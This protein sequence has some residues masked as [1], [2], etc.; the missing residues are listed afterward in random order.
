MHPSILSQSQS[1]PTRQSYSS[2]PAFHISKKT[3][4]WTQRWKR[5]WA[6][7]PGQNLVASKAFHWQ[8]VRRTKKM[9]S[10]QAR[11]DVGGRPPP[12][13]WVFTR[14]GISQS[15]SAH[16]S[17]GMRQ[18]SGTTGSLMGESNQHTQLSGNKCSCTKT[19]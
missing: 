19:L 16:K 1:M 7:E 17:S 12:K 3:P 15:I 11:S 10:I 8:P 2:K 5:S 9:A 13:G 4:C 14:L 6:V 18:S